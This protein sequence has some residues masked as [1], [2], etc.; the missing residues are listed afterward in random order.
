MPP[1]ALAFYVSVQLFPL[2]GTVECCHSDFFHHPTKVLSSFS[3]VLRKYLIYFTYVISPKCDLRC[4]PFNSPIRNA[5]LPLGCGFR[6]LS[7]LTLQFQKG[8][9]ELPY[10][11]CTSVASLSE[12]F[13][14]QAFLII[15]RIATNL[16]CL[17][18]TSLL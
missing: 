15:P 14:V 4:A 7:A 17:L 8:T 6:I 11:F 16:I 3:H 2:R 12:L 10:T 9:L 13:P 1:S 5:S 18:F